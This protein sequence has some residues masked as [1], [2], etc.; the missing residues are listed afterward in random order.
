MVEAF[1][2]ALRDT[3][4]RKEVTIDQLAE[5][6]G[7][8]VLHHHLRTRPP[9]TLNQAYKIGQALDAAPL[10]ILEP[11]PT[12][13]GVIITEG[14]D[15]IFNPKIPHNYNGLAL[16]YI[17]GDTP[18]Q[19]FAAEF[20]IPFWRYYE[21]QNGSRPQLNAVVA[22]WDKLGCKVR[23]LVDYE[24][25]SVALQRQLKVEAPP[26]TEEYVK[27]TVKE[28]PRQAQTLTLA[29]VQQAIKAAEPAPTAFNASAVLKTL[30]AYFP[31]S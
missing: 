22:L 16:K 21:Q 26:K 31:N 24:E 11:G 12:A 23:F 17:R 15:N 28:T 7:I 8:H 29:R 18:A 3:L 4:V 5:Q 1:Y 14:I 20:D 6:T 13:E 9:L 27:P 10:V 19:T 30:S 25:L 2:A